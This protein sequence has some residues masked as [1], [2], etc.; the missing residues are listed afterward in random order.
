MTSFFVRNL[1]AMTTQLCYRKARRL[2]TL[3]ALLL[4]GGMMAA[5]TPQMDCSKAP[6]TQAKLAKWDQSDGRRLDVIR[7]VG[8]GA[9]IALDI[10]YA[11]VTVKAGDGPLLKIDVDFQN[12]TPKMRPASYLQELNVESQDVGIKLRLPESPRAKVVI[13]IP[14]TTSALQ[15]RL[16]SGDLTFEA[17]ETAGQRKLKLVSGH[18][19]ILANPDS[20][21]TLQTR[22]LSGSFHDGQPGK[23]AHKTGKGK[24][25]SKSIPGTGEGLIEIEVERGR[26]DLRTGD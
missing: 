22:V 12:G 10:C 17:G 5:E 19:E 20:Y 25:I 7:Q 3:G 8:V 24:M 9:T 11:D 15:V 4:C 21:G 23:K 16:K 2:S 13:V 6:R 1:D 26:V 18:I 14:A